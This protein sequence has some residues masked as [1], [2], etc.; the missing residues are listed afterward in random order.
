MTQIANYSALLALSL[1]AGLAPAADNHHI[2]A[3][4]LALE[5]R[6]AAVSFP[7]KLDGSVIVTPCAGCAPRSLGFTS[8][9]LLQWN[10][11]PISLQ[12]LRLRALSG[13]PAGI[14]LIYLRDSARIVRIIGND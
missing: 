7:D 6:V 9:A 12:N 2:R 13:S 1:A 8:S 3:P 14:T 11:Q 5:V 10:G 4:E